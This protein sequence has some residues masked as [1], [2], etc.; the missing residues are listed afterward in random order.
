MQ[1]VELSDMACC[2]FALFERRLL[3][4]CTILAGGAISPSMYDFMS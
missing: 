1:R 3:K 2:D 4:S